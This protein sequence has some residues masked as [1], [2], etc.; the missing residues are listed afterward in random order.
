MML[1][2]APYDFSAYTQ[3]KAIATRAELTKTNN[4]TPSESLSQNGPKEIGSDPLMADTAKIN[5][6]HRGFLLPFVIPS[7][8][9]ISQNVIK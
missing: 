1:S 3:A 8:S 2:E 6:A 5:V 4:S 9:F 7:S